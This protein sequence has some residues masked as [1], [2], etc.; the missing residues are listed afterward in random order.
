MRHRGPRQHPDRRHM[1]TS[2]SA[3]AGLPIRPTSPARGSR[4]RGA[5]AADPLDSKADAS[6]HRREAAAIAAFGA[7]RYRT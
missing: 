4:D 3:A 7:R 1:S 6:R 2:Y 5:Q